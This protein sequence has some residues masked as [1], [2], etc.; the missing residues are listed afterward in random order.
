MFNVISMDEEL[1]WL[2]DG[3]LSLL[4]GEIEWQTEIESALEKCG[5]NVRLD[6]KGK[7]QNIDNTLKDSYWIS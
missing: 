5:V 6:D 4:Q 2:K 7:Q 1:V 3:I